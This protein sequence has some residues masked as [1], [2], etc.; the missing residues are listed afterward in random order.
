[1]LHWVEKGVADIKDYPMKGEALADYAG[2]L[3][4]QHMI[5]GGNFVYTYPERFSN[6]VTVYKFSEVVVGCDQLELMESRLLENIGSNR[7]VAVLYHPGWDGV[8]DDIPCLNWIQALV[9]DNKLILSVIFRSNDCY[10]AWP[11]NMLFL[12]YVGLRLV[13][14]LREIYPLLTFKGIDYHCSSLHIYKT[15]FPAV[16]KLLGY[17]EE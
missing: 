8:E 13:D 5:D 1:M 12:T 4:D 14:D 9:R 15:D 2:S 7:S 6:Y 16:K 3:D 10:G 11:A 17:T